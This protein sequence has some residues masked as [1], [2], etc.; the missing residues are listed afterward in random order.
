MS[1][2]KDTLVLPCRHLCLCG[3]C[4]QVL[5]MQGRT[6]TGAPSRQGRPKCPI[7][8]QGTYYLSSVSL[9]GA[10]NVAPTLSK[11]QRRIT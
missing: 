10:G 7:C 9:F 2:A 1:E 8:R 6:P 3:G 5:R 11:R 4:A